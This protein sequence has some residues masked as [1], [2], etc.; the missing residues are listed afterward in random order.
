WLSAADALGPEAPAQL[1]FTQVEDE[2]GQRPKDPARVRFLVTGIGPGHGATAGGSDSPTRAVL[3]FCVTHEG[4]L[5]PGVYQRKLYLVGPGVESVP[6]TVKL[7]VNQV[8]IRD[9]AGKPLD[10][11]YLLGL[12]GTEVSCT[13]NFRSALATRPV[14]RVAVRPKWGP[15]KNLSPGGWDRL[16]LRV[17][18]PA[19][20]AQQVTVGLSVPR[21]VQEGEDGTELA[22]EVTSAGGGDE[23]RVQVSLPVY[24]EVRHRG[25]RFPPKQLDSKGALWLHFPEDAP[26]P[27]FVTRE[28]TL[29]SDAEK[30]PV[31]WSVERIAARPGPGSPLAAD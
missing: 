21:C 2:R 22:F 4:K 9:R 6:L 13:L 20:G 7:A 30:V 3:R 18:G 26:A 14:K 17:Q 28:L 31:R 24:V 15:L 12:A 25:V 29:L 27:E 16:P 23:Q 19:G 8:S 1:D 11:L 10:E 5:L